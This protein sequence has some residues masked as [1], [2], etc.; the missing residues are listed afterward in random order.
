MTA[1]NW[2]VDVL[3]GRWE[4]FKDAP[5]FGWVEWHGGLPPFTNGTVDVRLRSGRLVLYRHPLWIGRRSGENEKWLH[6]GDRQDFI[7]YRRHAEPVNPWNPS[8]V[9]PF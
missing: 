8:E 2:E 7:A 1:D 9:L 5:N 6:W 4:V 3:T